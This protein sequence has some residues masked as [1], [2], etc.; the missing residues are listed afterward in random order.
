MDA[1]VVRSEDRIVAVRITAGRDAFSGSLLLLQVFLDP[2]AVN[3]PQCI[4]QIVEQFQGSGANGWPRYRA[5]IL[6]L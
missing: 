4:T 1:G 5:G 2:L 6:W 3:G